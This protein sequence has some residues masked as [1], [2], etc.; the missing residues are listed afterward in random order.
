MGP[1]RR[2]WFPQTS[3]ALRILSP[4]ANLVTA[5][6]GGGGANSWHLDYPLLHKDASCNN[7]PD[8]RFGLYSLKNT[9]P[10]ARCLYPPGA[11]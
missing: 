2:V 11:R 1:E 5:N 4:P 8:N 9:A 6:R 3:R 10:N 7:V